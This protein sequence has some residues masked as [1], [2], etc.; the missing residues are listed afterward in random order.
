MTKRGIL[1][2]AV[3][4]V[5]TISLAPLSA[6]ADGASPPVPIMEM[7]AAPYI[8][9]RGDV[10]HL[11]GMTLKS[12]KSTRDAH[13]RL[14]SYSSKDV[15]AAAVAYAALVAADTP[16]FAKTIEA[17]TKKRKHRQAFMEELN[18]NPAMVRDLDGAQDAI[19]AILAVFARDATR[20]EQLGDRYIDQAY[21]LQKLSWASRKLPT[22]GMTRVR[23]A[24]EW[25]ASRRWPVMRALPASSGKTGIKKPNL[26]AEM[27]WH[28]SWSK[29]A[30]EATLDPKAN[31]MVTKALVLGT[32]YALGDV[33]P[34]HLNSFATSKT[35]NRCMR[36]ARLM[37][38]QCMAATRNAYEE[39]FCIGTH[40]LHDV[41]RCVGWPS[42][43][44]RAK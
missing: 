30:K 10:A 15:A 1:G 34:G 13:F 38:D 8:F 3:A 40:G 37:L 14:S 17:K 16:A 36:S 35:T 26:N 24:E 25:S 42:N 41:S 23:S 39:A 18:A 43:A 29:V 19:D 33:K 32:R 22:D 9:L 28:D 5:V 20:I 6:M 11:E 44:G 7:S 2:V 4:T 31:V 12:D 27:M 21:Q